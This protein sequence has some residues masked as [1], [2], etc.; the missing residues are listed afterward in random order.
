MFS[1]SK[2]SICMA[3]LFSDYTFKYGTFPDVASN[4]ALLCKNLAFS[5]SKYLATLFG[6]FGTLWSTREH[7]LDEDEEGAGRITA[8]PPMTLLACDCDMSS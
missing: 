6:S 1:M 5:R 8:P 7:I 2:F 4:L 3:L